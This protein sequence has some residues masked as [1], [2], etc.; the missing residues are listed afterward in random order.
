MPWSVGPTTS[1]AVIVPLIFAGPA[2]QAC[3]PA[4]SVAEVRAQE[5]ADPAV[6]VALP[7]VDV[8]LRARRPRGPR[9]GARSSIS[10]RCASSRLELALGA[11]SRPPGPPRSPVSLSR[12]SLSAAGYRRRGHHARDRHDRD[13]GCELNALAA[14]ACTSV[15][16]VQ[17]GRY[18]LPASGQRFTGTPRSARPLRRAAGAARRGRRPRRSPRAPSRRRVGDPLRRGHVALVARAGDRQH[19]QLEREQ[20]VPDRLEHALAGG[21]QQQRQRR[22]GPG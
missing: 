22:P 2:G 21:A 7:E 9:S 19:R 6:D 14:H 8:R 5:R 20:L 11:R 10:S 16:R 15:G 3:V 12:T 18:A 4:G 13:R 1:A 17:F